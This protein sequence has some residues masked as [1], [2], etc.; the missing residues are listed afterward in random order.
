MAVSVAALAGCGGAQSATTSSALASSRISP[1]AAGATGS[2]VDDL[3]AAQHPDPTEFPAADGRSL[4]QL[5][6]LASSSTTLWPATSTFTPGTR[7]FAF[8]V[9]DSAEQFVYAP[10]AVYMAPT[11]TSPAAG[12]FL[13]PADLMGVAPPYRS[14]QNAGPHGLR[15]IYWTELPIAR[16]GILD[17][18]TLSRAAGKLIASLGEIPVAP[19]T[20]IPGVGQHP[21]DIA[22]ETLASVHGDVSLLTTRIP[23]EQMHSISFNQVLGKRPIAL[24][25]ST[26][27]LCTSRV[28]GPVTDIMVELQHQFGS[29]ITFIHQEIYVDNDPNKGRRPQLHAFHLESE[30]WLFTINRQGIITAR[31]EGAFGVNEARQALQAALQGSKTGSAGA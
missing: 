24:L 11:Q 26:P 2:A 9:T 18:L 19:T 29:R 7:R 21:P 16:P 23:P 27:E 10:T 5:A 30:P 3:V 17:V 14:V 22:T 13:A 15:A 28:C 25:F 12:P 20:P 4:N 8:G 31:L 1:A 6:Q